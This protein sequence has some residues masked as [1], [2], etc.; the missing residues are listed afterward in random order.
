[1]KM[2]LDIRPEPDHHQNV[3]ASKGSRHAHAYQ[4]WSTSINAFVN[5]IAQ[6]LTDTRTHKI[7]TSL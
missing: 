1:M 7:I 5:Y 3:T 4:V 2:I 6:S